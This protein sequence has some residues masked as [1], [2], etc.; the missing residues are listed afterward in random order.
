[1]DFEIMRYRDDY[2]I[3]VN[4]PETGKKIIK[5]LSNILA[6]LGMRINSEK[7]IFSNDVIGSSI[8]ADKLFWLTNSSRNWNITKHLLIIKELS[9]KYRNS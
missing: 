2:R 3:F 7:T 5:E 9:E 6:D 8:K 4:N 1:M